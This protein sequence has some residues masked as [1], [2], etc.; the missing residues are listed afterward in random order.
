[1][2]VLPFRSLDACVNGLTICVPILV[3]KRWLPSTGPHICGVDGAQ[4]T[5][6]SFPKRQLVHPLPDDRV[7]ENLLVELGPDHL[8]RLR[9]LL[10]VADLHRLTAVHFDEPPQIIRDV[11]PA[12]L[13]QNLRRSSPPSCP[14]PLTSWPAIRERTRDSCIDPVVP[15][16]PETPSP[17]WDPH[18][19][20]QPRLCSVHPVVLAAACRTPPIALLL[21][22]ASVTVL[23]RDPPDV[24]CKRVSVT[25]RAHV[26]QCDPALQLAR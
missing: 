12:L 22:L 18:C 7:L 13:L 26:Q 15:R 9:V 19:P 2:Q 8:D 5:C 10:Q 20:V 6:L 4:R 14:R 1:M 21:L 17:R 25:V 11:Q 24:I 3:H 16:G 23:H